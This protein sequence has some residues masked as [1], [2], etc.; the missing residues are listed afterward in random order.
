MPVISKVIEKIL[1]N[2]LRSYFESNK[3]FYEN[4]YG[5]RTDHSTEYAT[6]ELIDRIISKMDND[7]IPF[8]IFLDLSKAFDTI[9]HKIL[10][11][12]L[13]YYGIDGIPFQLFKSY[14]SDRKQYVEI[15]D[16]K[17]DVLQIT[18]GV[19]QGSILGP[20]LFIIYIND[21]SQASQVFNFISYAD[22]TV[23]FST[24]SNL[25]NPQNTDPDFLTNAE[26]FKINEWLEINKLSLNPAKTKYM[27]FHTHQK[28]VK[29]I[30]PKINNTNIEKVEEFKFL[31]LTLDTHLNWKIHSENISNK[32]SRISG[33]LNNLKYVL[34]E[35]IKLLLYN[36][37]LLPHI[38][39]CLMT[40]GYH[41]QRIYKIQ[42]RAIRTITLSKYY[43]HTA[44]LFKKLKLLTLKDIIVL[45]ELKFY[46]KFV[47]KLLPS[48]LQQWQLTTNDD[49]HTHNTRQQNELHIVGT[50]HT[51][52]K[53]CLKHNLPKTLNSI[54]KIV[55]DKIGTH[56]FRGFINYAKDSFIKST[57]FVVRLRT[58]IH[59]CATKINCSYSYTTYT[60]IFFFFS[61]TFAKHTHTHTHTHTHARIFV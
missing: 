15:N 3:L 46:F 42:K 45:Q 17:S 56:S 25:T 11:D 26:L 28:R 41:G 37:L 61:R 1:S 36:T 40:W 12:K 32:C 30:V 31:G 19:P 59:A 47:H 50:K 39:Y 2:Q 34:P 27:L 20:V 55:K 10:L 24:L 53:Q 48:Y 6:L 49:I 23:L 51:F 13:K 5:F 43:D 52:A 21:F 16:A 38:H 44:P 4:Q 29:S 35:R 54:P 33:I 18:T 57:K 9:D 22:D 7:E 8:S 60:T 58:A 14:L